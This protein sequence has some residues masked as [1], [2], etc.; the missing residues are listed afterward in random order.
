M[1]EINFDH[2]ELD[3]SIPSDL[4]KLVELQ[5]LMLTHNAIEGHIPKELTG[6][7]EMEFLGLEDNMLTGTIPTE[8]GMMSK[9]IELRLDGNELEVSLIRLLLM[10]PCFFHQYCNI[11]LL[12]N[13]S[14][15]GIGNNTLGNWTTYKSYHIRYVLQRVERNYSL[16][17]RKS[18]ISSVPPSNVQQTYWHD[19]Y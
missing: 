15:N 8:I 19:S 14:P 11:F 7:T 5:T 12:L 18:S 16:R 9:L 6:L 1:Q 2:N 10:Y 17:I 4:G 3:G 13:N